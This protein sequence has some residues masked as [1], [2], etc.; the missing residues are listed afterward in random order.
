LSRASVTTVG[1]HDVGPVDEVGDVTEALGFALRDQ[2][3]L[4]GVEADELVFLPRVESAPPSR[5]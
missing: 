4:R 1:R 2:A 3:V 5:A